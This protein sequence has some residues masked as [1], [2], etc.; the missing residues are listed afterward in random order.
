MLTAEVAV[1][2]SAKLELAGNYD[3]DE[4]QNT[5]PPTPPD[6]DVGGV[7]LDTNTPS[8]INSAI[9]SVKGLLQA[10]LKALAGQTITSSQQSNQTSDQPTSEDSLAEQTTELEITEN[11]S[12]TTS[13]KSKKKKKKNKKS[14]ATAPTTP[15][16]QG[17]RFAHATAF[18]QLQ[19][20][21]DVSEEDG[22]KTPEEVLEFDALPSED[23]HASDPVVADTDGISDPRVGA[24]WDTIPV[25]TAENVNWEE[26]EVGTVMPSFQSGFWK[27]YGNKLRVFGTQEGVAV[28]D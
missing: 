14:K 16:H 19:D 7:Q 27:V 2:L 20:S 28:L 10:P 22:V 17:G 6:V 25:L 12:G 9:D 24:A 5:I 15:A 11:E 13:K 21:L 26:R 18:D 1:R 3:H 8:V 4:L 23:A